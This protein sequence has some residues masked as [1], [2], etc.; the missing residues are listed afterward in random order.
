MADFY[1]GTTPT[2]QLNVGTDLTTADEVW[3]T[4]ADDYGR[5]VTLTMTDLTITADTVS[6]TLTQYQTLSLTAGEVRVQLRALVSGEASA[7]DMVRAEL[8]D[9]L[10]EGVIANG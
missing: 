2:I 9:I 10:K 5:E 4:V 8:G 6:G 7:T 3:L 1:R